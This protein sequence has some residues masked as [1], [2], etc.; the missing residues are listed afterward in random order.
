MTE[1]EVRSAPILIVADREA[2]VKLVERVLDVSDFTNVSS[3]I[4]FSRGVA[5]CAEADP[6]LVLVDV[7]TPGP[8][9]LELLSQLAPWIGGSA[10]LPVLMLADESD[11]ESR[12]RALT[13]GAGDV[14]AKPFDPGELVLRAERLLG[15]R[16][17]QA[18]LRSENRTLTA[19]AGAH[20]QELERVSQELESERLEVLRRLA[21][22]S[23]YRDDGNREH[24]ERIG[25]TAALL[26]TNLGLGDSEAAII[27][28]AAPLHDLGKLG[29]S[30]SILLNPG[31]LTPGE[32]EL[33]KTHSAIGAE[34]LGGGASRLL[35]VSEEI[36]LSHHE[37]W[38]GGG[39]PL[40]Q[41]GQAIPLTGR[42]VAVADTFDVITHDR[43]YRKA[44]PVADAVAEIL[45]LAGAQFDP[46]VVEAFSGL[47]HQAL[48]APVED[49]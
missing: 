47:D 32:F 36:A 38:D 34:I 41:T 13:L 9:G 25:R 18:R 4:D 23:E 7:A 48:L 24:T 27:R 15:A 45:K 40:G 16:L 21:M 14:V 26:A 46:R 44:A 37:R 19:Q 22:A 17:A 49:D 8:E 3:T 20:A 5:M 31:K 43:P 39:Y 6:D 10:P 11:P 42:M 35:Q 1:P 2:S 33:M 29:I 30:D 28:R 12:R